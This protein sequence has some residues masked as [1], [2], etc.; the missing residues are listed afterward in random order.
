M[1]QLRPL[2][3]WHFLAPPRP[4]T[5]LAPAAEG[6]PLLRQVSQVLSNNSLKHIAKHLDE[7]QKLDSSITMNKLVDIGTNVAQTGSQVAGNAFAKTVKVGGREVTVRAV[8][9]SNN[10]LRSVHIL[11]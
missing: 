6:L 4:A 7:F 5:A 9:N 8:L 10:A 1:L 11:Q 2:E 3:G